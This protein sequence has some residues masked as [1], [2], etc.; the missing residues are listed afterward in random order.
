MAVH[1]LIVEE[2]IQRNSVDAEDEIARGEVLR[3]YSFVF[4]CYRA[5]PVKNS[6]VFLQGGY[7]LSVVNS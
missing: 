7:I 4:G 6:T 3:L 2:E 5:L 1:Q